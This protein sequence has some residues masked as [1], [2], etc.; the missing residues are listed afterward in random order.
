MKT[1]K[2]LLAAIL[3][4]AVSQS[5]AQ[6]VLD[7]VYTKEHFQTKKYIPYPFLR[8]ADV[9][10]AKRVWRKIDLREKMNH[11]LYFP[12]EE[13]KDRKSM[14][15][16]IVQAV[17]EGAITA[18]G[19]AAFDDEFQEP[20]TV[21][22]IKDMLVK[23]DTIYVPN[24]D[25]P[26]VME[27]KYIEKKLDPSAIKTYLVKE[28]WFFDKQRSV[29]EV[30]IIG[31]CPIREKFDDNTGEYRGDEALFW[32]YFPEMRPIL[33]KNEVYNPI[34]DSER[35]TLEDVFMKR[36]FASYI[37]KWSNT[38]NRTIADYKTNTMDQLLEAEQIKEQ[39]FNFEHD[40]W[41]Y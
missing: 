33:A 12:T 32:L 41:N 40:V 16:V 10:W 39:I 6:N 26:D 3:F 22:E 23:K 35:R 36:K 2:L 1:T 17:S 21:Q 28:D 5:F 20:M 13:I 14:M 18:Y 34:N 15:Q 8:E 19:N 27:A 29:L 24:A 7:G 4:I 37:Y 11:P 31:I 38:F 30:R 25:N 9:M